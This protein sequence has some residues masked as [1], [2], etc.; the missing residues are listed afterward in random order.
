MKNFKILVLV[1]IIILIGIS[2]YGIYNYKATKISRFYNNQIPI[3]KVI[4]G[5]GNAGD[6]HTIIKEKGIKEVQNLLN[7]IQFRKKINQNKFVG[8]DRNIRLYNNDKLI[9]E[10]IFSGDVAQ[11]NNTYYNTQK[12][13]I[14][15]IDNVLKTSN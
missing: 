8:W 14:Q 1:L 12:S 13:F 15:D 4:I 2:T 6:Y 11:I 5:N 3:T 9:F 7:S 10:V